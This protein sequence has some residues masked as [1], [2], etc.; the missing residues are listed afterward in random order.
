MM[1]KVRA[2]LGRPSHPTSWQ[3]KAA[4]ALSKHAGKFSRVVDKAG[5]FIGR[6]AVVLTVAE[7]FY[8]LG[9]EASCALLCAQDPT[10]RF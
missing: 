6:A 10:Q 8:D 9:V 7:G 3:H 5:K 4:Q 2:G 1:P